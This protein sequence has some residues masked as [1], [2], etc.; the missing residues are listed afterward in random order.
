MTESIQELPKFEPLQLTI[1]SEPEEQEQFF[2][3]LSEQVGKWSKYN[4]GVNPT[5][6]PAMGMVEELNELRMAFIQLNSKEVLDAIGDVT[7]Y[8]ADYYCLRGWDM[9]EAWKQRSITPLTDPDEMPTQLSRYISHYHLKGEQGIRGGAEKHATSM[10]LTCSHVF[11]FLLSM[12]NFLKVDYIELV[13]KVWGQVQRRD[14]VK[15]KKDAHIVS[16]FS[17]LETLPQPY[18]QSPSAAP[19]YE[20]G[21]EVHE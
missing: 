20:V 1:H 3:T 6:R 19:S 5:H 7:I 9:G 12:S 10:H 17:P 18:P 15:N 4:F 16:E 21:D 14:W 11:W 13:A 8:M 2:R